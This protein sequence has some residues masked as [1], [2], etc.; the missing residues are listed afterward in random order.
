MAKVPLVVHAPRELKDRL[1]AAAEASGMSR[2]RY[3]VGLLLGL[4]AGREA[5]PVTLDPD[6]DLERV[7]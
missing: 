4:L 5:V 3:V 1:Q 6:A 7:P 2:S